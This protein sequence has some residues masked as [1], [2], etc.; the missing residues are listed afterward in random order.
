MAESQI[1]TL[2]DA[3]CTSPA[4]MLDHVGD[5]IHQFSLR[6][7]PWAQSVA[8]ENVDRISSIKEK[9]SEWLGGIQWDNIDEKSLAL[10]FLSVEPPLTTLDDV[11]VVGEYFAEISENSSQVHRE[12]L[13]SDSDLPAPS[14]GSASDMP[15]DIWENLGQP[16]EFPAPCT[17]KEMENALENGSD[18]SDGSQDE[19]QDVVS[20]TEVRAVKYPLC[21]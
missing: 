7:L 20:R 14:F 10:R 15:R 3:D 5:C 13:P 2:L 17:W 12:P 19:N 6:A 9:V 1:P 18:G 11:Y 16:S 21:R 8:N 4:A